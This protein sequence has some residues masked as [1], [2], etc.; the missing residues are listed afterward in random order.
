MP[1]YQANSH[2][3]KEEKKVR[4]PKDK[5]KVEKVVTGD[6]VAKKPGVGQKL[7]NLFFG[8]EARG[9]SRYLAMD[10]LIPAVRNMV[11]DAGTKGIERMVYGE[12]SY[13]PRRPAPYLGSRVQY[14]NPIGRDPR[15]RPRLPD[16]SRQ[17][18]AESNDIVLASREDAETV[19][20]RLIDIVDT[21]DVAS[22]ADLYDLTGLPTSHVDNKWGWSD[23]RTATIKQVREGYLLDLPPTEEI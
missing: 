9:V 5:E 20:E 13:R 17:V 16:Q 15:D 1:D 7:K 3:S 10:V 4:P 21:Y 2:R 8:G 23:L 11:V 14:N 6:V 22:L 18:R 19:L 12:S